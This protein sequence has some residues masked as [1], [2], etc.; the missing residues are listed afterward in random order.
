MSIVAA[1]VSYGPVDRLSKSL[2]GKEIYLSA[3]MFSKVAQ[4]SS[5]HDEAPLCSW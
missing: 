5:S 4:N 1:E 2:E 3:V